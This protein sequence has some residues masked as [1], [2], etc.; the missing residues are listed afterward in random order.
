MDGGSVDIS[1]TSQWPKE[2][3]KYT[4]RIQLNDLSIADEYVANKLVYSPTVLDVIGAGLRN[5]FTMYQPRGQGK[6]DVEFSGQLGGK[7]LCN[8]TVKCD[9]VTVSYRKFPYSLE[10]IQGTLK[11]SQDSVQLDN[12]K[13]SH[14]KVDVDINGYSRGFGEE[15]EYD[16]LITSENMQLDDDLYMALNTKQKQLWFTFTPS[17][18]AKI[19]QR[20]RKQPGEKEYANLT[21]ELD[22]SSAV[23]QHFPY[24]LK[25][26]TGKLVAEQGMIEFVNV[27]SAYDGKLITLNGR[28]TETESERPKYN[29]VISAKNIPIDSQLK[30]ALP[31]QQRKF[32][33]HFTVN[34]V[35]DVEINVF[36]NEVGRRLVEYI[37]KAEIKA[38]SLVYK[39][40][41]YQLNN[42]YVRADLTPDIVILRE[43]T[44][45]RGD[46]SVHIS[47]KIWPD[48]SDADEPTVCLGFTTHRP[49]RSNRFLYSPPVRS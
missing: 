24:Q 13:C 14:G 42:V 30:M 6:V 19:A 12:L 18:T 44:G 38:D 20:I 15:I 1:G 29:I 28:V 17:G 48:D 4:G 21:V 8:G 25:N 36:P 49:A 9:D 33:E 22:G 11:V 31:A 23:Y 35:T 2:G 37:A 43:L 34:A 16:V 40:F 41:P 46:G 32:Y 26:L 5:F 10:H 27:V 3:A 47:G 39:R 45:I 7:F